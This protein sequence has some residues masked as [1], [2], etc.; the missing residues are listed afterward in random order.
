MLAGHDA[1]V[2]PPSS[3]GLLR[4]RRGRLV[5]RAFFGSLAVNA[6]LGVGAL[7]SPSFGE[8]ATHVLQTSLLVSA[9]LLVT[10]AV[11]PA[12]ES[13]GFWPVPALAA[14]AAG[15]TVVL[16]TLSVW[17]LAEGGNWE[18]LLSTSI[19]TTIALVFESMFALARLERRYR[20]LKTLGVALIPVVWA[21]LVGLVWL[22]FEN[23]IYNRALGIAAVVLAAAAAATPVAHWLS[24]PALAALESA[25]TGESLFCPF[26]G[27]RSRARSGVTT[28]CARCHAVYAVTESSP[29][30]RL[31]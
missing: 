28:T 6:A 11:G 1:T 24:R 30:Q 2:A 9:F 3:G 31:G 18:R 25:E 5:V 21:L 29:E 27:A 8:T 14:G 17:G 16:G 13:H 19:F 15:F 20:W 23:G 7:L 22:E 4:S 10:L 12:W 26:C